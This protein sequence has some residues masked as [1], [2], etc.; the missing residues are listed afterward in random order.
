MKLLKV[1]ELG[2]ILFVKENTYKRG[3]IKLDI[4]KCIK[5]ENNGFG[6]TKDGV[7]CTLDVIPALEEN[8]RFYQSAIEKSVMQTKNDDAYG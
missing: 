6:Y 8:N 1:G 5:R 3:L 2:T 4:R 7:R